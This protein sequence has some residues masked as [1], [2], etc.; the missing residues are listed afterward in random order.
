MRIRRYDSHDFD[1]V[2]YL[3]RDFYK[4]PATREELR[5]KLEHPAW[6]VE[7]DGGVIGAA[8]TCPEA[9]RILLW[10][11]NVAPSYRNMGIGSK[12]LQTV[13]EFYHDTILYLYVEPGNPARKLYYR[14][15]FRAS[16][17]LKDHF[18]KGFDTIEMYKLC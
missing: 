11:I 7:E 9:D 6:V 13:I 17:L 14:H 18:G 1:D 3:Q 12:L 10:A 2:D 8:V 4:F 5:G 16:Q 15:G